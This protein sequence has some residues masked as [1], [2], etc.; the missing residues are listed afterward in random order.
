MQ[1]LD[2]NKMTK[3]PFVSYLLIQGCWEWKET[4]GVSYFYWEATRYSMPEEIILNP[5]YIIVM[6]RLQSPH[7]P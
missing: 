5:R 7:A 2:A 6:G 4:A 3:Q 1:N